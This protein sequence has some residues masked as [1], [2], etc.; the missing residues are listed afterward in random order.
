MWRMQRH[1][2]CPLFATLVLIGRLETN[3]TANQGAGVFNS[4]GSF[5]QLSPRRLSAGAGRF[6]YSEP[7]NG[8]EQGKPT[9]QRI[10]HHDVGSYLLLMTATAIRLIRT[11]SEI[12][13]HRKITPSCNLHIQNFMK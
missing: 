2:G 3:L 12:A 11:M 8:H 10:P 9:S 1:P 5:T 6:H 4:A 13:V 7:A